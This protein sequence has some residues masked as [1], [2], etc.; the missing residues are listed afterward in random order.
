MSEEKKEESGG[1]MYQQLRKFI[2]V[3]VSWRK[4]LIIIKFRMNWEMSV[5][6]NTSNFLEFVF[7]ELNLQVRVLYSSP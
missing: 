2:N 6:N 1:L 5:Y 4:Q 3:I 7:L